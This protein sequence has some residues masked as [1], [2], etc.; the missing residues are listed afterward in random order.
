MMEGTLE[1]NTRIARIASAI[2]LLIC[3]PLSVWSDSYVPGKIFVAQDPVATANNLLANEFLFRSAIIV[4]ILGF[5]C[6]VLMTFMFH[7]VFSPV[8]KFLGRLML[9]P[10]IAQFA[11]GFVLQTLNFSALLVLKSEI[12]AGFDLA[13][14]QET[15]Y[16]LLRISR[17]GLGSEKIVLG[18]S[19]I[20]FGMLVLKSGFIPRIFGILL[21]ISGAGYVIDTCGLMLLDRPVYLMIQPVRFLFVGFL[22][23]VLWLLFKGVHEKNTEK[24]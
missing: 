5:S 2:F 10:I 20:P 13:A 7:R 21:I 4:H 12:R 1:A 19:F 9:M 8:D 18:L 17:T 22:A 24:K 23:T 6:F 14:Q 11:I 3:I 16:M 15:A